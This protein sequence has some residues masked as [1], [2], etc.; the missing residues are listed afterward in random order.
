VRLK[1]YGVSACA[2]YKASAVPQATDIYQ[3]F[4]FAN[5]FALPLDGI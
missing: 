3:P 2:C 5:Y 4:V 1:A